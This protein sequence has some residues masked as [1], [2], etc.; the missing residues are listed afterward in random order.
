MFHGGHG[1]MLA[2]LLALD[3]LA[4][5]LAMLGMFGDCADDQLMW[6]GAVVAQDEADGFAILY[7]QRFQ[8]KGVVGRHNLDNARDLAGLADLA[9]AHDMSGAVRQRRHGYSQCRD[10]DE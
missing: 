3:G 8:R 4:H 10:G 5:H 1:M 2:L 6:I 7:L 9:A